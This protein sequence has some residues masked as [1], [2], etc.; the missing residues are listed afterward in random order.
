[1]KRAITTFHLAGGLTVVEGSLYDDKEPVVREH[2][3][4]FED[5]ESAALRLLDEPP[6]FHATPVVE[7]ATATPGEKRTTKR[8]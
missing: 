2:A 4:L 3:A 6:T 7:Q 5:A 8:P 1:M